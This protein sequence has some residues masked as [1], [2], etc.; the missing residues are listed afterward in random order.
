MLTKKTY[1]QPAEGSTDFKPVKKTERHTGSPITREFSNCGKKMVS[2]TKNLMV[3]EKS[4]I[5]TAKGIN[6]CNFGIFCNEGNSK[7]TS[8]PKLAQR[9][10]Y[11]E[12]KLSQIDFV[13]AMKETP[14]QEI[15]QNQRWSMATTAQVC[16]GRT[17]LCS[18]DPSQ[19]FLFWPVS[20]LSHGHGLMSLGNRSLLY[21]FED[22][23][24]IN[25][26]HL[27]KVPKEQTGGH[28]HCGRYDKSEERNWSRLWR[29][30]WHKSRP[31][32]IKKIESPI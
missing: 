26:Q 13:A 19:D 12:A 7:I 6:W 27:Q 8:T 10:E 18:Q 16:S 25:K 17:H 9:M 29:E 2:K 20:P 5:K 4:S 30:T 31:C 32:G 23:S 21:C 22:A 24:P 1:C 3:L 11:R 28:W 15:S 14:L